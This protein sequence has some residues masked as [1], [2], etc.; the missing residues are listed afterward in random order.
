MWGVSNLGRM[1]PGHF[2]RSRRF[3]PRQPRT[4]DRPDRR[5]VQLSIPST[6]LNQGET[7]TVAIG[8][9]RGKNFSEDVSLKPGDLP[10]GVTLDLASALIKHGDA[11]AKITLKAAS[12]AALGD[13]TVKVT[14]HPTKGADA[15]AELKLS[16]AKQDSKDIADATAD[17]AK[18]KWNEYTAAM[19]TQLD[20]FNVKYAA[21]KE[22]AARPRDKPRRTSMRNSRKRKRSWTQRSQTRRVEIGKRRPLGEGQGRRGKCFR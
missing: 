20:Q 16:V 12:D 1:R 7:K 9:S 17:A 5:Y 4:L 21:L 11:D 10:K 19:Q 18:A 15:V 13:F 14:G 3:Q 6:K 2:G 8:I 22:S